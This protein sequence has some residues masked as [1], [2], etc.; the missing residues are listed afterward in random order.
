MGDGASNNAADEVDNMVGNID[1]DSC[2]DAA[3]VCSA[4]VWECIVHI[5]YTAVVFFH[6]IVFLVYVSFVV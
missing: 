3:Y 1:G 2:T 6:G 4:V 5:F